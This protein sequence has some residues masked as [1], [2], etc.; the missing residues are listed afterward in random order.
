VGE[1]IDYY[2]GVMLYSRGDKKIEHSVKM[3]M[4]ERESMKAAW[5]SS[6]LYLIR[7]CFNMHIIRHSAK[8]YMARW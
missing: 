8:G 5:F 2:M 3:V 6:H 7:M 1:E 4:R